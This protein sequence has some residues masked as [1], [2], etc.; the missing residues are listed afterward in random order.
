MLAFDRDPK[1]LPCT[2]CLVEGLS[3]F[4]LDDLAELASISFRNCSLFM[5]EKLS[6][7]LNS[8]L[9]STVTQIHPRDTSAQFLSKSR[10]PICKVE[11]LPLN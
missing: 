1:L 5:A 7:S 10:K 9:N 3:S 2:G 4:K 11:M 8:N 6:R